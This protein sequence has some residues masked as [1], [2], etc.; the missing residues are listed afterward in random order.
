MFILSVEDHFSAAH[1]VKGYSGD[2][3]GIH[4]HTYKVQVKVGIEQLDTLGMAMD[5]RTI[6]SAL[7][8]VLKVLDH[9]NLNEHPFF[10][11]R[12]ATTEYIAQFIF[13]E[14]KRKIQT[15]DSVTVWEGHANS[16]TYHEK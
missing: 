11:E 4:G 1:Q 15:I 6:Q 16:I 12:N 13:Q 2:C 7:H 10:K 5:F 14:I 9:S 3:A 8:K